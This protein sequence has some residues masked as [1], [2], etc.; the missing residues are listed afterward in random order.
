MIL[1]LAVPVTAFL[2]RTARLPTSRI[3]PAGLPPIV[4]RAFP[5]LR[6]ILLIIVP[7]WGCHSAP[8]ILDNRIGRPRL[9]RLLITDGDIISAVLVLVIATVWLGSPDDP[10][11]PIAG[12][13]VV[14]SDEVISDHDEAMFVIHRPSASGRIEVNPVNQG[15]FWRWIVLARASGRRDV[16]AADGDVVADVHRRHGTEFFIVNDLEGVSR[17]GADRDHEVIV[18]VLHRRSFD[19]GSFDETAIEVG[20][21]R[22]GLH[23]QDPRIV[24]PHFIGPVET[25]RHFRIGE[26]GVSRR[27]DQET[28]R[29]E[30]DRAKNRLHRYPLVSFEIGTDYRVRIFLTTVIDENSVR[31]SLG[32]Q[33]EEFYT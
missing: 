13:G 28:D 27:S 8:V 16:I 5:R 22:R 23:F 15:A 20:V 21:L 18:S 33:F 14:E 19:D 31:V 6:V 26:V 3:R 17:A 9:G 25:G 2:Q 24:D 10:A 11:I 30:D 1:E 12:W 32:R 7:S 29:S 4:G